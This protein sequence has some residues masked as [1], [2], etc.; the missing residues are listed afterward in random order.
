MSLFFG[1][2][3]SK[4]KNKSDNKTEKALA[5]EKEQFGKQQVSHFVPVTD[6]F[7]MSF[8]PNLWILKSSLLFTPCT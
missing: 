1:E 5:A 6:N 8:P 7:L 4:T 3:M 2:N